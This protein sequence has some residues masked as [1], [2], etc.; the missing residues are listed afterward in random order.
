MESPTTVVESKAMAY[1]KPRRK[2]LGELRE[3][4]LGRSVHFERVG[5][6]QLFHANAQGLMPL[7]LQHR[8]VI[9]G[10]HRRVAYIV[11]QHQPV[12]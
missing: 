3:R 9:L 7:V 8:T 6:R 11:Q 10:A 12:G 2:A 1:C 5:I 4:S